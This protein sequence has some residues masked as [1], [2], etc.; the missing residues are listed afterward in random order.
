MGVYTMEYG[1]TGRT[2]VERRAS[3]WRDMIAAMMKL[4]T[5]GHKVFKRLFKM[6]RPRFDDLVDKI[7]TIVEAI[8][9]V[10]DHDGSLIVRTLVCKFNLGCL[11]SFD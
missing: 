7:K 2:I 1:N 11:V 3:E 6:N 8:A 9:G 5:L 4:Y 10:H